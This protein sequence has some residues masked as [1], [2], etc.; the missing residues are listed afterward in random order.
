MRRETLQEVQAKYTKS[1]P[2]KALT[3]WE[4]QYDDSGKNCIHAFWY[5]FLLFGNF[6]FLWLLRGTIL[7][8]FRFHTGLESAK[9]KQQV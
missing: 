4:S 1:T 2:E 5:I 6:K 9:T 8:E 3:P 7:I